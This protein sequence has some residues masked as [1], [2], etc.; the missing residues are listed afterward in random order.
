MA[1]GCGHSTGWL[2]LVLLA[3]GH[4]VPT[5]PQGVSESDTANQH[6]AVAAPFPARPPCL[7]PILQVV[8]H[9]VDGQQHRRFQVL[10]GATGTG[11][12]FV[13]ANIVAQACAPQ[14]TA[15]QK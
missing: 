4:C 10:K 8:S 9:L 5:H 6:M 7:C 13:M 15:V 1:I 3:S 11:K 14:Y 2:V 12:T